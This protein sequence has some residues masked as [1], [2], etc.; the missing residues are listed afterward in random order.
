MDF[1]YRKDGMKINNKNVTVTIPNHVPEGKMAVIDIDVT[2][3]QDMW[4]EKRQTV[5]IRLRDTICTDDLFGVAWD[6]GHE[7][8][9]SGGRGGGNVTG[10]NLR[11]NCTARMEF[12]RLGGEIRL[13]R[14]EQQ[15]KLGYSFCYV[16]SVGK[17]DLV[18]P[19]D[20][21]VFVR[22]K[23]LIDF[24][25]RLPRE[26]IPD[27]V[28]AVALMATPQSHLALSYCAV[29]GEIPETVPIRFIP[30]TYYVATYSSRNHAWGTRVSM[31]MIHNIL[32]NRK[33]LTYLGKVK[34]RSADA[35]E[36]LSVAPLGAQNPRP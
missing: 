17:N 12:E 33:E 27:K 21:D 29:E 13:A 20:A 28:S 19:D 11:K 10:L 36:T 2:K 6:P 15:K 8:H 7:A 14:H 26:K 3:K 24:K 35:G 4:W 30:G 23:N 32:S 18:L 9:F 22:E 5:T 34:V 1:T 31:N 16:E 25:L